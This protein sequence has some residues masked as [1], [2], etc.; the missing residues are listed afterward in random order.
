MVLWTQKYFF[1]HFTFSFFLWYGTYDGLYYVIKKNNLYSYNFYE[2]TTK[3]HCVLECVL[4]G[5]GVEYMR[6]GTEH[7]PSSEN[8]CSEDKLFQIS[9]GR[10]L[11]IFFTF[12]CSA[13]FVGSPPKKKQW[14]KET[15]SFLIISRK[16]AEGV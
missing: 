3:Q 6:E 11:E 12:T 5:E 13:N 10:Q 16:C 4:S 7:E 2:Q 1:I 15:V 14:S 9:K 8:L